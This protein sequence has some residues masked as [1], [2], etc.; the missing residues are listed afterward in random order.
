MVSARSIPHLQTVSSDIST[1][2][3]VQPLYGQFA[4]IFGRRWPILFA[5]S[6]FMLGSGLC[7]GATS[8]GM[9]I[10][11]RAIQGLGIGGVNVMIDCVVCD[12]V[13]LRSRPN[14]MGLIYV[15]FSLGTSIG[16][17]VGGV[18]VDRVTWRWVFYFGL[19]F[20]AVA[21]VLMLLFLQ[22]EYTKETTFRHKMKRID[23]I[24]NFL[25]SASVIAILCALTYG[26]TKHAWSS[27]V[28][29]L[30]LSSY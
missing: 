15:I 8:P 27:W 1:S 4:N 11:G 7:G 2:T 13:P 9:L 6:T 29:P 25:L 10:A 20:C 19:P 16:P 17:F 28:C 26:G 22:V 24:G 14:F 12:L 5:I 3:I 30:N 23:W 18:F 21:L